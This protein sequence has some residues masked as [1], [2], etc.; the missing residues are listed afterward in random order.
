MADV[1]PISM[2]TARLGFSAGSAT[3]ITDEQVID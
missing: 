1:F 3:T 2:L